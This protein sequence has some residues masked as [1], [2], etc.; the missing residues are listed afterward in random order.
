MSPSRKTAQRREQIIRGLMRA[1]AKRGYRG[2]PVT[3]IAREADLTPGLVHYYFKSK[4]QLLVELLGSIHA[5]AIARFEERLAA[6]GEDP[7]RRLFALTD[8]LL[9]A[10]GSP[11][12]DEAAA[13]WVALAAESIHSAGVRTAYRS[14]LAELMGHLSSLLRDVLAEEKRSTRGAGAMAMAV[15]AAVQGV[16]QLDAAAPELAA[17]HPG[18]SAP[19]LRSMMRGLVKE[20]PPGRSRS[21][22]R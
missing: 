19:A 7:W 11:E 2:A 4:E 15:A 1:V 9:E 20:A 18:S 3:E 12:A 10:D 22:R 17:R 14:Q 8:S 21:R 16:Y 5:T 13:C 6:A